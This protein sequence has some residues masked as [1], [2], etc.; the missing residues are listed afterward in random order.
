[1][2][3]MQGSVKVIDSDAHFLDM[4]EIGSVSPMVASDYPHWDM[5]WPDSSVR[6]WQRDDLSLETK[7]NILE[8]NARRFYKLS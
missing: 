8:G 4:G 1:M 6:I 7:R 5:S 3:T 2:D